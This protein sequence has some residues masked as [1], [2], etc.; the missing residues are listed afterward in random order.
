MD[1]DDLSAL[2]GEDLA[3]EGGADIWL[4]VPELG[5]GSGTRLVGEA[6]RLADGLGCYVQVVVGDEAAAENAIVIGADRVHV[7][8]D[9]WEYVASQKPEFVL[10]LARDNAAA[11]QYAETVGAGLITNACAGLSIE[12]GTRALLGSHAVY[13]GEF[14]LD[15]AVTSAVKVATVVEDELPAPYAD[16][17]RSGE[18]IRVEGAPAEGRVRDLG[19]ADYVP[20]GWRPLSKARVIVSVGRG[21]RDEAGLALARQLAVALDAELAGDR[22]ALSTGWIDEA[23]EVGVTGQEVAPELYLALGVLGDTLHNAAIIGARRVIAVHHHADAPIFKVADAAV[24]AEP[25]SWMPKL[26][27]ALG[28]Q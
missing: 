26:L 20:P 22:S 7:V 11:A 24:V 14:R 25:K 2:M 12:D 27:A 10:S 6:R 16:P 5:S 23:H 28:K 17:G 21:V 13:G 3:A 9:A 4:V 1:I 18:T 8:V 19:P 15:R